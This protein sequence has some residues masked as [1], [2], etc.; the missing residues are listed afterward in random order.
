[1]DLDIVYKFIRAA[2]DVK[3]L[4]ILSLVAAAIQCRRSGYH[5]RLPWFFWF[6]ISSILYELAAFPEDPL[7]ERQW[8]T[9][10]IFILTVMRIAAG[11][12]AFL[13]SCREFCAQTAAGCAALATFLALPA[14]WGFR[15]GSALVNAVQ[16]RL[17]V[18]VWMAAFCGGYILF[19]WSIGRQ[20]G[21]HF[22]LLFLLCLS[23]ATVQIL[24]LHL[25]WYAIHQPAFAAFSTIFL[26]WAA[27]FSQP[28]PANP[29]GA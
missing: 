18:V 15:P 13:L 20:C 8:W 17:V 23:L 26:A 19:L 29:P 28:D 27:L 11:V 16:V 10:L 22:F 1:M 7:W 21:A 9:P 5:A 2:T 3:C 4:Y 6:L 25:D 24:S 12:E 14:V